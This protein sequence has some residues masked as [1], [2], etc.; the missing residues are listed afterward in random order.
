MSAAEP[1]LYLLLISIHGLIRG[2]DLELGRDADTGGQTLYVVESGPR[3]GRAPGGRAR[4]PGHPARRRPGRKPD[5]ARREEPLSDKAR[6]VRIDCGPEGYLPKEQLWD[7]LD[8]FTDNLV[9]WIHAQPRVPD[10]VH[11]HYADAGYVGV[12]L[13]RL[14]A[15]PLVH[16]GHSLGRDK[17]KRLLAK[18]LSAEEIDAT[19]NMRQRIHAEEELL[20]N[21]DLVITSTR[22]EIEE[23]YGL[24]N[25][26][27]ARLHGGDPARHRPGAVPPAA[28]RRAIQRARQTRTVSRRSRQAAGA[29]PVATR[30]AQ[31]HPHAA[32]GVPR[33]K[34]LREVANL[35]I[36]AGNRDDIRDLGTGAQVP[37][38]PACC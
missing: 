19:Y 38:S 11:S 3:A 31:E 4:R 20:A 29:G 1:K 26:Y 16:T 7:H 34:G 8:G 33:L 25:Y 18:G 28:G 15:V 13:A 6:I 37:C 30:R 14:A 32:R 12:R 36:I 9:E 5:Y 24:Y 27:D 17:R 10:V 23:Q 2:H 22:N 21:A 35:L